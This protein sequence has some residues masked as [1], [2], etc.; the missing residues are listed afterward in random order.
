MF[1]ASSFSNKLTMNV[2]S[3]SLNVSLNYWPCTEDLCP[4]ILAF[5]RSDNKSDRHSNR[6]LDVTMFLWT[7]IIKSLFLYSLQS[8]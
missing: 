7:A 1:M 4:S 2:V 5:Q 3:L 6:A 8:P